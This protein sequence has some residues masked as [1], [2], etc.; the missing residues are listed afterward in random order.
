MIHLAKTIQTLYLLNSNLISSKPIL[1]IYHDISYFAIYPTIWSLSVTGGVSMHAPC[2]ATGSRPRRRLAPWHILASPLV[3]I[4]VQWGKYQKS[5]EKYGNI[6][7]T[8]M[9]KVWKTMATMHNNVGLTDFDGDLLVIE[10]MFNE[11]TN[12]LM[13]MESEFTGVWVWMQC[14]DH[15][16]ISTIP[17]YIYIYIAVM[18]GG[19]WSVSL[20]PP[21][22]VQ[23][24]M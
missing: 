12:H 20:P 24:D 15:D 1:L 23:L 8:Y 17:K 13:G 4:G 2:P 5:M 3:C 22:K 9:E 6:Y 19:C 21:P 10:W 18:I 7:G 16:H 11:A 14:H